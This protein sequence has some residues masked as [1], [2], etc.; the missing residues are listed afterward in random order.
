ML[1]SFSTLNFIHFTEA[2]RLEFKEGVNFFIGGNSTGKSAVLEL[3]RRC[4]SNDIN[5]TYSSCNVKHDIAYAVSH[6]EIPDGISP[7]SGLHVTD[8][9]LKHVIACIFVDKLPAE[10]N[11]ENKSF[12]YYK[13]LCTFHPDMGANDQ[14]Y[15]FA[16]RYK[17]LC[18]SDADALE[19]FEDSTFCSKWEKQKLDRI[20]ENG[21]NCDDDIKILF[22]EIKDKKFNIDTD[23][24][25][26]KDMSQ[27]YQWIESRYVG[28]MSMRSIGPLQWTWSKRNRHSF[29][30]ENY[31][32]ASDRAE[33][34]SKL[35][36][37]DKVDREL[38]QQ[39]SEALSL[40]CT[41]EKGTDDII[42]VFDP[43][44]PNDGRPLLKTPEGV[45]EAKQLVLIL[46]HR[47]LLTITLE[48]PDHGMHDQMVIKLREE[49]LKKAKRKTVL[50]TSHRSAILDH[51]TMERTFL[52]SKTIK[53]DKDGNDTVSHSVKPIPNNYKR[54]GCI[55]EMNQMLFSDIT[56]FVPGYTDK[57]IIEAVFS[58]LINDEDHLNN[59]L[60]NRDD[61]TEFR[62][63]LLKIFVTEMH[64]ETSGPK[65]KE[66]CKKIGREKTTFLMYDFDMVKLSEPPNLQIGG[67]KIGLDT[68][69]LAKTFLSLDKF[70][71]DKESFTSF[72][73]LG[74]NQVF[75]WKY[76]DIEDVIS[77]IQNVMNGDLK[78]KLKIPIQNKSK[79]KNE[80]ATIDLDDIRLLATELIKY[81]DDIKRLIGFLVLMKQQCDLMM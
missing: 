26:E 9:I 69:R 12:H 66:F 48:E 52:F 61:N 70:Y 36:K 73:D 78:D 77:K 50:V 67:K 13:V 75:V 32:I 6:F 34:L 59:L 3:I 55:A 35:L 41:F 65:K 15:V 24:K 14:V 54:Y 71:D 40:T 49:V 28:V 53:K 45:L 22:Y 7:I 47:Q 29:R 72:Q 5:T 23:D 21:S 20:I 79:W 30:D 62:K 38:E 17:R 60:E 31:K 58:V 74:K 44:K 64:G 51:E 27:I 68:F 57:I 33:I 76:G 56:F 63:F 39:F 42:R 81:N 80:I 4:L 25:C 11:S 16:K 18:A 2:Q 46:S 43:D 1:K 19:P 10:A 8:K 37:D